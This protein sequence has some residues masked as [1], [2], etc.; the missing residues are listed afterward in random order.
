M[1]VDGQLLNN[2]QLK[3]FPFSPEDVAVMN[4]LEYV[5]TVSFPAVFRGEFTL[6]KTEEPL[7]TF[8]SMKGWGKVNG[9]LFLFFYSLFVVLLI[10]VFEHIVRKKLNI[11]VLIVFCLVFIT[12]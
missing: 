11:V 3:G 12:L 9:L 4:A 6:K 10:I 1:T 8:V 7:D 2:W 5:D